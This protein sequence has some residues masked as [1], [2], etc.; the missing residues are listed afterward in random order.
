M[1][2]FEPILTEEERDIL[3]LTSNHPG[4]KHLTNQ[5]ISQR[6]GITI[7]RVKTLMHQ[8]CEKLGADNRNEAVVL[9]MQRREIK[10]DDLFTVGEL[11]EI[12]CTVDPAILQRIAGCISEGRKPDLESE[13]IERFKVPGR[14]RDGVLT[15]REGD[16]LA[17]IGLGLSNTE[18]AERL[19]LSPS[20]VRTFLNRAFTKLGARKRADAL[21]LALKRREIG[22]GEI[23]PIEDFI[24]YLTPI[25]AAAIQEIAD[26]LTA[27]KKEIGITFCK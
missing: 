1:D 10:L 17:L 23:Y 12:L 26:I 24:D 13:M 6:L 11:A 5:E 7:A 2:N 4:A 21:Q 9:A 16:V 19:F 8:A 15:E 3:I 22:V 14:R 27:R 25:G 18:I 20:A